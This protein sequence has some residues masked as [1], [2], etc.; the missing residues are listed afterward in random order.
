[1]EQKLLPFPLFKSL[2]PTLALLKPLSGDVVFYVLDTLDG[3]VGFN[4]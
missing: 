1:M 4:D 3:F 2:E